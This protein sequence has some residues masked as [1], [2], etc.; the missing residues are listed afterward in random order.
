MST[1]TYK[2]AC[3]LAC[4]LLAACDGGF[5]LTRNAPEAI[6][7]PDGLVIAGARGW[8]VDSASTRTQGDAA[9]VVLGSCAALA[10]N[11]LLPSPSVRGVVTVSV[12]DA[13]VGTLSPDVL[14][15]FLKTGAGRAA[16]ARDGSAGSLQILETRTNDDALILH[17][18][19]RSGWPRSAAEDYWRAL[20]DI[21]GRFVSVSLVGLSDSPIPPKAGLAALEAQ[22]DRLKIANAN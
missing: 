13:A 10:R 3:G 20:F 11:A 12:E 4:A 8:C 2:A 22:V 7:L 21:D 17:A 9:V 1:W 6:A 5:N 15:A 16:L 19:D 14:E 18:V